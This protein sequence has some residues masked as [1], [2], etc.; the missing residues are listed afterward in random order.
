MPSLRARLLNWYLRRTLKPY[1]S[2]DADPLDV[3]RRIDARAVAFPAKGVRHE[4]ARGLVGGEWLYPEAPLAGRTILYLHG[5]GYIFGTP[6]T[7]RNLT[8]RLARAARA[9]TFSLDYRRAP[10]D[11]CPAA[12]EDA[13]AAYRMLLSS[14][15][16][17]HEIY[18]G[19]DSAGG[20]LALALAQAAAERD[21]PRPGGLF[22]YSPWTDLTASGGS[23]DLNSDTDPMFSAR[24]VRRS[25]PY[26]AAAVGAGDPRA[27]PLFGQMSGLPRM[28][29][30]ASRTEVLLDDSR[31]LAE[32]ARAA[33]VW[34]DLRIYD[35]APH[36]W[37]LFAPFIREAR[38]TIVETAE[39][40]RA[41]AA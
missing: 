37:P 40:I 16:P 12:V 20:G 35:G 41:E 36:A 22:L 25:A 30:F 6:Q 7:H 10:E 9:P 18:I 11:P 38:R 1:F 4:P 14:G 15:V 5:G 27:S 23:I 31:R 3:R 24:A 32:R 13:A 34:V 2:S 19:G 33:G 26:Y 28:L 29:V 39:F 17:A 21:M 8:T